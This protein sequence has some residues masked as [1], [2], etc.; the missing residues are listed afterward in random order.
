MRSGPPGRRGAVGFS[1]LGGR[2][3]NLYRVASRIACGRALLAGLGVVLGWAS[4]ALALP[5]VG[6]FLDGEPEELGLGGEPFRDLRLEARH[7]RRPSFLVEEETGFALLVVDAENTLR[8]EAGEWAGSRAGDRRVSLRVHLPL[9]A[10]L[11]GVRLGVF[12]AAD[13]LDSRIE[14]VRDGRSL[15]RLNQDRAFPYLGLTAALPWGFAVAAGAEGLDGAT[16]WHLEGRW[17]L[18]ERLSAWVRYRDEGFRQTAT[19][20]EGVAAR[21]H[22]PV[23]HLP[24]DFQHGATELG[25]RLDLAPAWFQGG[26]LPGR[27]LGFWAEVGA[28][29]WKRLALRAGADREGHHILDRLSAGGTGEIATVDL[30]L[31]RLRLFWG[32]DWE[33][34]PRDRLR[35]RHV[36]SRLT[37]ATRADELETQA[38]QAFLHVD[39]DLGLL[40]E[41]GAA[42]Q[43]HQIGLAWTRRTS[44][45]LEFSVG[46]QYLRAH[47]LPSAVSLM[48]YVLDRA[49]AEES[50]ER[51]TAH[52]LGI[53]GHAA[54]HLGRFRLVA[55]LGQLVPLSLEREVA[56]APSLP[57]PEP[58]PGTSP[59]W[60]RR[61]VDTLRTTSGGTRLA[62]QVE[63]DF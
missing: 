17:S 33:V 62:F 22:S 14:V 27:L 28:R 39:T 30:V 6:L 54:H 61:L 8:L 44:R 19:I 51:L 26:I 29:P 55:A 11:P 60:L 13:Q 16:R 32:A 20:P 41:G 47:T 35:L 59:G 53:S 25:L 38:A 56:A 34:G 37:A 1:P 63:M 43:V 5:V 36:A 58:A 3:P 45:N 15:F 48:S 4:P 40:L 12:A 23:V 42:I 57:S 24:L 21:V 49:L 50:V 31:E 18:E 52:L 10:V 46:A 2:L 7:L 9:G